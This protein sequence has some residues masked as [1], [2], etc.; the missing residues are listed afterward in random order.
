MIKLKH[1]L[2]EASEQEILNNLKSLYKDYH[3]L[4]EL[5]YGPDGTE[6]KKAVELVKHLG[7]QGTLDKP[8]TLTSPEFD[9]ARKE[10]ENLMKQMGELGGKMHKLYQQLIDMGKEDIVK[11]MR[12]FQRKETEKYVLDLTDQSI[13]KQQSD[14]KN[15]RD[16]LE[17][18][19]EKRHLDYQNLYKKW[20]S[21]N[22]DTP[23]P[24]PPVITT[25]L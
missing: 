5:M 12:E 1:L 24:M 4:L 10:N 23:P 18:V 11:K 14:A 16:E 25:K 6:T 15:M 9:K 17:N 7:T 8:A 19:I 21:G 13:L 22:Q 2:K 3:K 20:L